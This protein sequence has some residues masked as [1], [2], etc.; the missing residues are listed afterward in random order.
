MKKTERKPVSIADRIAAIDAKIEDNL[1]AIKE[2]EAAN[3]L[4]EIR[5]SRLAKKQAN[6]SQ[7]RI[8]T[9]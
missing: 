4:L 9:S 8:R 1:V 5:K 3:I 7:M 6:P 2:R